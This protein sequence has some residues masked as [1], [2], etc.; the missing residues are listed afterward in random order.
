MEWER[1]RVYDGTAATQCY[2]RL[3]Y[4]HRAAVCRNEDVCFKCQGL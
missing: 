2:K 3:G 4:N 1:C